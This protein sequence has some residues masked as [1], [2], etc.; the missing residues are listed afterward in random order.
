MDICSNCLKKID[1]EHLFCPWCGFP[2][3]D[4]GLR[5][6]GHG[7]VIYETLKNCPFCLLAE[8]LGKSRLNAGKQEPAPTESVRSASVDNTVLEDDP[9]EKT[10]LESDTGPGLTVMEEDL[11]EKTEVEDY[12]E[13]TRVDTSEGETRVREPG[14]KMPFAAWVVFTD[15]EDLPVQDIRLTKQR[16]IIGKGEETDIRLP[17]DFVSRLHALIYLEQD[18]FYVSDLG[19]TNGTFVNGQKVMQEAL[20]DGDH[21][22]IG[23]KPMIFKQVLK[24]IQ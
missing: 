10:M 3:G 23:H 18:V 9:L 6:C 16:T 20:K 14:E 19:S 1:G 7:H 21:L 12:F 13:G 2:A 24:K 17:D 8:N 5:A 11:L 15:E 22:R 4:I